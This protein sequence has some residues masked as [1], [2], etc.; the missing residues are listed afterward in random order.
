MTSSIPVLLLK[1]K[2]SPGDSYEDL[3]SQS[4]HDGLS[5]APTFVP[6]LQHNF[7]DTGM[8]QVE[9]LLRERRIGT[10]QHD[11]YGGLIFTS[12]RAVEAFVKL[13]EDGKQGR[14]LF[15]ERIDLVVGQLVRLL[16]DFGLFG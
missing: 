13:V 5:F 16:T 2:S 12:Q 3:F 14:L 11:E 1:T 15:L 7:I 10:G 4:H 8:R 6:V 9:A